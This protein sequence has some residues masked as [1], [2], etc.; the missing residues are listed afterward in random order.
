MMRCRSSETLSQ[1]IRENDRDTHCGPTFMDPSPRESRC[2]A[3]DEQ[4]ERR[5]LIDA[6]AELLANGQ[7]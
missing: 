2:R 3:Q 7:C 1:K 6:S 4:R 5:F